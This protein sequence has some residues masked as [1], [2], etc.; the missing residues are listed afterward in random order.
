MAEKIL[1][2]DDHF[3]TLRLTS[4]ILKRKSYT[5]VTAQSGAGGL[6]LAKQDKPDL[7]LL[8]IMMPEMDGIEVCQRLRADPAF[9]DTPIMMFTARSHEADRDEALQAGATDYIVKPTRPKELLERVEEILAKPATTRLV[10]PY[11]ANGHIAVGLLGARAGLDTHLVA[12]H[13]A[14]AF[15]NTE[16]PTTLVELQGMPQHRPKSS[17]NGFTKQPQ[18][19]TEAIETN[20]LL[21][22]DLGHR[23]L[24]AM[25]PILAQLSHIVVCFS[26]DLMMI[27]DAEAQ[28][29][30]LETQL[31]RHV[32]RHGLMLQSAD[33]ELIGREK[34][35]T[36]LQ[37]SVLDVIDIE[38]N[39]E[40]YQQLVRQL[41][42]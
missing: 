28:L 10:H 37:Q 38:Y 27:L 31:P 1:V 23:I 35:E 24:P 29:R 32:Q 6:E 36:L 9:R 3:E 16:R 12:T 5:V 30:A 4:L 40:Q 8:D 13:L 25:E 42:R 2:I 34:V 33:N 20:E 15:A 7:I 18:F 11:S 17:L 26:A 21:V 41:I 14:H 19:D 39:H 22:V